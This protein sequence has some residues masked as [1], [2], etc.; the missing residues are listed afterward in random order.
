VEIFT[1]KL[2][3]VANDDMAGNSIASAGTA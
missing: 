2:I 1:E 3:L